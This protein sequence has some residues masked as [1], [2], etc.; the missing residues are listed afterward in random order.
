MEQQASLG[1][2]I[3]LALARL[4]IEEQRVT[5]LSSQLDSVREQLSGMSRA[6]GGGG[7]KERLTEI[8]K[9]LTIEADP[10]KRAALESEQRGMKQAMA[11]QAAMEQRLRDRE[12]EIAQAL[13][14]EQARWSDMS[15]RLDD[16]ERSLAPVR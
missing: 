1:P 13:A 15:S 16:L 2:R 14:S 5:H 3:Q 11:M 8:E 10:A 12:S 7:L 9:N 6:M 4:S